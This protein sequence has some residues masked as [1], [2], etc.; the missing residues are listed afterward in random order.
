[1]NKLTTKEKIQCVKWYFGGNSVPRVR[2]L[3]S[4][5]YEN[6]PIPS[7]ATIQRIIKQFNETGSVAKLCKNCR[8]MNEEN[9]EE[10]LDRNRFNENKFN[11]LLCV[12]EN[13]NISVRQIASELNLHPS[14]VHKVLKKEKYYS[15]KYSKHQ[16]LFE[17]DKFTRSVFCET[18]IEKSN[19]D[20][21]FLKMICFTDE[22]TFTIHGEPN[23]QN[24]RYWSQ[25]NPHLML[26]THTQYPEKL[27]VWAGIFGR[28]II[29]P[30][31]IEN[32]LNSNKYLDMLQNEI[33]PQL[34]E[35]ANQN[36]EVWYEHDGCPAHCSRDIKLYLDQC[37]PNS[38]IGRG[39]PINWPARSPDL[40]PC[41]FFLWPYLKEKVYERQINN[42]M[43]LRNAIVEEC[44]NITQIQ[45]SSVRQEFYNRLGYCLAVNGDVF[46]HL[47]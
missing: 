8:N 4:D 46:E 22:S 1:M 43:E 16:E 27:N 17:P 20:R 10:N 18:I 5:I 26:A 9:Q 39:G 13:P 38:W 42:I 2:D 32:N 31:F 12:T 33:G 40:A 11:I 23:T 28:F 41:D 3:F 6:R 24:F 30:F 35:Y 25:E 15:Y 36:N 19:L 45:L 44:N 7:I 14:T 47:I 34:E 37:F 21:N 29:G